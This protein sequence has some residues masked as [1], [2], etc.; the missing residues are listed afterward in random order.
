MKP[1]RPTSGL[2]MGALFNILGPLE[3][4]FLDLFAG[5]GRVG[6]EAARRGADPVV[7]VEVFRNRAR[8]LVEVTGGFGTVLAMEL[9]RALG[10]MKRRHMTFPLIFADPPYH[11][12]WGAT[13][14]NLGGLELDTVLSEGGLLV[15]EHAVDEPLVLT[16]G[17]AL[18]DA[19][20]YGQTQLSFLR[21][22]G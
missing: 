10:W 9:R 4:G 18:T 2:V 19:R 7:W 3:G 13:L 20:T 16:P 14:L 12:G 17:W 15:V 5:T 1:M 11:E 6:L 21:R 8:A 22:V